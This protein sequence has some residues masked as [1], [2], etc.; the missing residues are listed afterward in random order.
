MNLSTFVQ[1]IDPEAFAALDIFKKEM[2][3]LSQAC[4]DNP[5]RNNIDKVRLPGEKA[6]IKRYN[7]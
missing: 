1:V 3:F 2:S 4:L 5:P 7:L 6:L